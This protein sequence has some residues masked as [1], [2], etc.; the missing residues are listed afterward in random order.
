M[1]NF[2]V[3]G[4]IVTFTKKIHRKISFIVQLITLGEIFQILYIRREYLNTFAKQNK[5][6]RFTV[7]K[8]H[9]LKRTLFLHSCLRT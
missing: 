9:I 4:R 6:I 5:L 7:K 3:F 1:S 8:S 2:P